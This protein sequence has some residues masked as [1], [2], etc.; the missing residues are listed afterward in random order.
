MENL[1]VYQISKN[2]LIK[3]FYQLIIKLKHINIKTN[4]ICINNNQIIYLDYI[5][6][7]KCKSNFIFHYIQSDKNIDEL[8]KFLFIN[9][10][11]FYNI[12]FFF[13]FYKMWKKT[14]KSLIFI[15][16]TEKTK[17]ILK[18]IINI[19]YRLFKKNSNNQWIKLNVGI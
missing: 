16:N 17:E 6:W 11:K 1:N 12:N 3:T 7:K 19:K 4:I 18:K 14:K 13:I 5:I 10:N 9:K 15:N 2:V 8:L